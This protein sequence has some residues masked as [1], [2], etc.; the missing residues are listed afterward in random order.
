ML[1]CQECHFENPNGNNFCQKCGTSLTHTICRKC[2]ADIPL[3]AARCDVCGTS[4]QVILWGIIS[5]ENDPQEIS[6]EESVTVAAESKLDSN[7]QG[8]SLAE[9]IKEYAPEEA[10]QYLDSQKRYVIDKV[11][12]QESSLLTPNPIKS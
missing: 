7:Y 5:T 8:I 4:N 6:L 11:F 9:I 2:G 12:S 3:N 1:I 10:E